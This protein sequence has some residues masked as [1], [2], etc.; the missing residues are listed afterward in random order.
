MIQVSHLTKQF[1]NGKGIFDV[2]FNVG[3]GEVLGFI[4]PNGAGKS[5]TIRHL[6]GFLKPDS[7]KAEIAGHDC[8]L[9]S[10]LVKSKISYLPGEIVF[11]AGLSARDFL[12]APDW[13]PRDK[14]H[15]Q[16]GKSHRPVSSE[17]GHCDKKHVKGHE[18]ETC[19][20]FGV[21]G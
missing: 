21:H 8:W 12:K 19:H 6:M 18:A 3:E 16:N 2:S 4:G 13:N 7:G 10:E 5:T 1:K 15:Q 14:K 20:C 11:P 17:Y 9:E